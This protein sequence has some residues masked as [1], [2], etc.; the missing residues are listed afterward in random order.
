LSSAWAD[1]DV[2][3]NDPNKYGTIEE[4]IAD[5]FY[6][7]QLAE[8][9]RPSII[10]VS[11]S[12]IHAYWL[13]DEVLPVEDW[14]VFASALKTAI[15]NSS[16][17]AD[18]GLT[19]DASRILRVPGTFNYKTSTPKPVYLLQ[20]FCNGIR[21]DFETAFAKLLE[22]VPSE[23]KRRKI[24]PVQIAE[25]FKSLE[26]QNL[27]KGIEG[28]KDVLI[29]LD[30]V[31][32]ECGWL[33]EAYE[34]GGKNYDQPQWNLT[35]LCATFLENG[36]EYAHSF[37]NK[38]PDYRTDTTE[39]LWERK[40]RERRDKGLG[41]PSCRAIQGDGSTHCRTCQHLA[42]N[43]SPLNFGY[44]A[45]KPAIKAEEAS[46]ELKELGGE[47]PAALRLPEGYALDQEGHLCAYV[48]AH[49]KGKVA[50]PG[51]LILLIS[52]QISRP[53]FRYINGQ[54]GFSFVATTEKGGEHEVY[55]SSPNC[56]GAGL[57]KTLG[58][59]FVIYI[60]EPEAIKHLRKVPAS[61]V[62]KL[63][64]EGPAIRDQ[65]GMGWRYEG[66]QLVGFAYANV[67]Y[68]ENGSELPIISTGDDEFRS[69]YTPT[70]KKE[71]WLRAAKLLTD[72]K[73]PELDILIAAAFA[74]PLTTFA[75]ALYGVILSEWGDPGTSKSTGQQVAAAVWGHPKQTR[76]S[77]NSTPKSVQGRLGRTR[78]LPAYWDDVQ[79]EKHQEAL[80][81]TMFVAS[82]GAEGGRLN[83]DATYKQR[84]EWQ[85]IL[86]AC[87]NA[88]FVEFLVKKQKSTTAGMRRVFEL[89]FPKQYN[90]PG[91][92]DAV[93]AG[94]T[95]AQLEHNFGVVG[96]E[97]AKMLAREHKELKILVSNTIKR[98]TALVQGTGD[99]SFWWGICGVLL[100]GA[101][102][103]C[104]LGAELN[105]GRMEEYLVEQF[106]ENRRIR[107]KEGTEGGSYANTEQ[108]LTGFLNQYSGLGTILYVDR[109]FEHR[110]VP[111]KVVEK[112]L[113][114]K[115]IYIQIARD[116]R[117]IVISKRA[118]REWLNTNGI[119]PRGVFNGLE[120]FFKA[121]EYKV[122][123]GAGTV[124]GQTQEICFE[125][126]V[127]VFDEHKV[128]EDLLLAHGPPQPNA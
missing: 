56:Y 7:C 82:E 70:G 27:A 101:A 30:P 109:L 80:F 68:H 48:P 6:F 26:P 1:L 71:V 52:S 24:K 74:A 81:Q 95:F 29:P 87:S 100:V 108:A 72:R 46:K 58:E 88:S 44:E 120:H 91:M 2:D 75:G 40:N 62:E 66:D 78:N 14:Q 67:L 5:L 111:V 51:R 34:T 89:H 19:G 86:V 105:V 55:L 12:G 64:Q 45:V 25:A 116:Q 84:L 47:R 112:P 8:I 50:V 4:A 106:L 59:K 36:H 17:K 121:W 31:I 63:R 107:S 21:H 79:D 42:K 3:P 69:W 23:P 20:K 33:R 10:V 85:T 99:E 93:D 37:G 83:P 11:G 13:S 94:Q 49:W 32:A 119:N 73:R 35:T 127:P 28:Y 38:H 128:L 22:L 65:H 15:R 96:V 60:D 113:P 125:I 92:I 16:L 61:W 124:H 54:Y 104:R 57:F 115:P 114:G 76:E 102:A 110:S 53:T 123:L 97:Y 43:K 77:L 18:A 9:P 90:E 122:T 41:W 126:T 103:A 117:K 39:D 98:F 118:L